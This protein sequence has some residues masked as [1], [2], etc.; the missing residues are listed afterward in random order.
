MK[1][2]T[3]VKVNLKTKHL[4]NIYSYISLERSWEV[5][6]PKNNI[7]KFFA[8][9]VTFFVF[10]FL[11]Q[12]LLTRGT[13]ESEPLHKVITSGQVIRYSN[14]EEVFVGNQFHILSKSRRITLATF[15]TSNACKFSK[16]TITYKHVVL[17]S[18]WQIT[19]PCWASRTMERSLKCC[20]IDVKRGG[21][22]H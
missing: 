17:I 15:L 10:C 3:H 20:I 9:I 1:L 22:Y 18:S 21:S 4:P 14:Q 13:A 6:A 12:F 2:T 16:M 7:L 11:R 8:L 5:M 19:I